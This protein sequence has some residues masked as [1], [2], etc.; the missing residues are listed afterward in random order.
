[1]LA[2]DYSTSDRAI[3]VA[4]VNQKRLTLLSG[5]SLYTSRVLTVAGEDAVGMVLAVPTELAQS[6]FA[7][8]FKQLWGESASLSWRTA[9]AYDAAQALLEGLRRN[10]NRNGIQRVLLQANFAATGANGEVSFQ[11]SGDRQGNVQLVTV[12]PVKQGNQATYTFQRLP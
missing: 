8:P 7:K 3:Q 9:L 11:P 2:P 1:M 4:S 5:D 10:P 12:A 6:E